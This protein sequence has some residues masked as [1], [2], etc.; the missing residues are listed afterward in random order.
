MTVATLEL[1]AGAPSP[2]PDPM[3]VAIREGQSEAAEWL[4]R[5]YASGIRFFLRRSNREAPI[6]DSVLNVIL[7]SCRRIRRRSSL[8]AGDLTSIV[9][10]CTKAEAALVRRSTEWRTSVGRDIGMRRR[11]EIASALFT[12]LSAW[13]RDMVMRSLL[14]NQ[15]DSEI[16]R[17]LGV[18]E[19]D[20]VEARRRARALFRKLSRGQYVN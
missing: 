10:E 4:Y 7:E 16:A 17:D 1:R 2:D 8:K 15:E 3:M 12:N 11:A 6:D 9:L 20:I 18:S 19:S 13:E 5:R 14:L